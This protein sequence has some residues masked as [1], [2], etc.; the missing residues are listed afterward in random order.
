MFEYHQSIKI[1]LSCQYEIIDLNAQTIEPIKL[2]CICV[3]DYYGLR[4]EFKH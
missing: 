3:L 4:L 2:P 1:I